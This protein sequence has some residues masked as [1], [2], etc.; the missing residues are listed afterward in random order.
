LIIRYPWSAVEE[1]TSGVGSRTNWST[2]KP[3]ATSLSKTDNCFITTVSTVTQLLTGYCY[4][5]MSLLRMSTLSSLNSLSC[6]AFSEPV[7][8][9]CVALILHQ[10]R[11]VLLTTSFITSTDQCHFEVFRLMLSD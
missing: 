5:P 7:K 10:S 9:L 3:D 4:F 2:S 8:I 11:M 6:Y 1:G